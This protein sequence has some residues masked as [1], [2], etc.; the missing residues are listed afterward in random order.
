MHIRT[1]GIPQK[2]LNINNYAKQIQILFK[3]N[4]IKVHTNLKTM[5]HY[6]KAIGP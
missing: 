1:A 5:L 6:H 2:I 4:V 3:Q